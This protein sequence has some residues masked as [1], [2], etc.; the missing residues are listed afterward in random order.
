MLGAAVVAA[1]GGCRSALDPVSDGTLRVAVAADSVRVRNLGDR[2]VFTLLVGDETAPL[3]TWYPC[4]DAARCPPIAPGA[5]RA[6][7]RPTTVGGRPERGATVYWWRAV[8]V[9]GGP[10]RPDSVRVLH[11]RLP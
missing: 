4:V 5:T 2:P 1:A 10:A 9:A 11:V 7:P 3:I 6:E 8:L